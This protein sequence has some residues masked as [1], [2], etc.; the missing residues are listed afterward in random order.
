MAVK[1]KKGGALM[2]IAIVILILIVIGLW[3]Y[4]HFTKDAVTGAVTKVKNLV[5]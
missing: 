2:L 4:P 1:N 5:P 3:Y